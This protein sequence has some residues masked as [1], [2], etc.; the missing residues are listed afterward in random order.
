MFQVAEGVNHWN[1][2][3]RSHAHNRVLGEGAKHNRIHPALEVVRNVAQLLSRAQWLLSL[4]HE[5]RGATQTRHPGFEG[6]PSSQ[7]RLLKEHHHLLASKRATKIR[8]TCLHNSGK[9]KHSFDPGRPKSRVETR[10]EPQ[11]V[12]ETLVGTTGARFND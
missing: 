12:P 11:K 4:V 8:R 3:V 1:G 10:S 2:G 5:E 9:M 7:R 6:Q